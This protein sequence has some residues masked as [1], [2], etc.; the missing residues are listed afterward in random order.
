ML[1][2]VKQFAKNVVIPS[3]RTPAPPLSCSS[4][5]V[6]CHKPPPDY[7]KDWMDGPGSD[8]QW[9]WRL[10]KS[11]NH[12]RRRS[13]RDAS[14]TAEPRWG[15]LQTTTTGCDPSQLNRGG[16][17]AQLQFCECGFRWGAAS[18][19]KFKLVETKVEDFNSARVR[20][21]NG[22]PF[23]NNFPS[24]SPVTFSTPHYT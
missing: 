10:C 23:I 18:G 20:L 14:K 2:N 5:R 8:R 19:S 6:T 12:Q 21:R 15:F 1:I 24:A 4:L 11:S 3:S 17:K 13:R 9:R 16:L 7:D 22:F